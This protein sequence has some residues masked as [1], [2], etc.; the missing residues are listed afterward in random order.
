MEN[1]GKKD[2]GKLT[3]KEKALVAGGVCVAAVPVVVGAQWV[4]K[5]L[6]GAAVGVAY[7][8]IRYLAGR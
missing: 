8:F 2:D 1:Q 4:T 3:G 6:A 7:H 5:Q